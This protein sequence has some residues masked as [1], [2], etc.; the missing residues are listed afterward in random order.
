M[1]DRRAGRE[2]G[3]RW[4]GRKEIGMRGDGSFEE[5]G[6]QGADVTPFME[7]GTV[8]QFKQLAT[9]SRACILK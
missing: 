8:F 5:G 9:D 6:W 4:L 1:E 7:L 3:R 2:R